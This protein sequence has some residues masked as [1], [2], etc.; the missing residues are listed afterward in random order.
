MGW[1]CGGFEIINHTNSGL[2]GFI[3]V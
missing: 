1:V 2:N 3:K